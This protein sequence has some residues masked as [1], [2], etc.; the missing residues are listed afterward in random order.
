MNSSWIAR[1]HVDGQGDF[2]VN[3]ANVGGEYGDYTLVNASFDYETAWGN[4]SLQ[5]HNLLDEYYEYVFDLG[6]AGTDLIYSPG[7]GLNASVSVG[8]EF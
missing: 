2:F 5:L 3:E 1:V 8:I 7:D 4:V 6:A